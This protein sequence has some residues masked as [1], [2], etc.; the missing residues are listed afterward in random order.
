MYGAGLE[1]AF[2]RTP[3]TNV[4]GRWWESKVASIAAALLSIAPTHGLLGRTIF[5]IREALIEASMEPQN[6]ENTKF[7][8]F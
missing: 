2:T 5:P 8:V 6:T 1:G 4:F 7:L 3:H